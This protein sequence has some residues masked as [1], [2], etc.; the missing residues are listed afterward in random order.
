MRRLQQFKPESA[1]CSWQ[2]KRGGTILKS[3]HVTPDIHGLLSLEKL[4]I[5]TEPAILTLTR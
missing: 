3:G 4:E 5:V 2:L 1:E